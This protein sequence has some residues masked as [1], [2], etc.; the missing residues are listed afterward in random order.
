MDP[1][2][3]I[4]V[5]GS[6]GIGRVVVSRL[7]ARNHRVIVG[8][9]S[10]KDVEFESNVSPFRWDV[11]EPFPEDEILPDTIQGL[12][13]CP[14][15]INL[16]SLNR[17]TIDDFEADYQINF[18]GAVRAVKAFLPSLKKSSQG[19]SIVLFST[20]AVGTGM[21]FHTSIASAKGAVEGFTRALAAELAPRVRVN[22]IAPSLT[23]TP[24]AQQMLSTDA[25]RQAS[26][27]RHPLKRTGTPTDIA[28]MAVFLLDD[29]TSWISGQILRVDGGL[30]S[31]RT[32]N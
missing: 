16:A 20:V 18:L 30:S 21:P 5:G 31:L 12:V 3:F 15:T 17:L 26:E 10:A 29:E 27:A 13:Y 32:F 23:D 6:S 1:K 25:K 19:A 7:S 24:L 2:T 14:G 8:S 11:T 9:R 4:V 22:A 28:A